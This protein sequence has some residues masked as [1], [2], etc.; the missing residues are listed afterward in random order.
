MMTSA[1]ATARPSG[2]TTRPL[3]PAAKAADDV[4]KEEG[5]RKKEKVRTRRIV[6]ECGRSTAVMVASQAFARA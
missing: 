6:R 1:F 3:N 5:K 2:S 4:E